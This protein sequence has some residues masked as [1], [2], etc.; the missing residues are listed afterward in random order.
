MV[1]AHKVVITINPPVHAPINPKP[2]PF[3]P[4]LRI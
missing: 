1:A 3:S 2:L 4:F